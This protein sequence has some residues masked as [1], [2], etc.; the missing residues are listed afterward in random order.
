[1]WECCEPLAALSAA[2]LSGV[3]VACTIGGSLGCLSILHLPSHVVGYLL[4]VILR[5][6]LRPSVSC[7]LAERL[8]LS[9]CMRLR[10]EFS[11]GLAERLIDCAALLPLFV[12]G[13]LLFCSSG[14]DSNDVSGPILVCKAY[15]WSSV[16]LHRSTENQSLI[17]LQSLNGSHVRNPRSCTSC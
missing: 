11:Y 15:A 2:L 3:V 7:N 6:R 14:T 13:M 1:M 5:K 9:P 4:Q 17:P 10:L 16:A 8:M 12:K